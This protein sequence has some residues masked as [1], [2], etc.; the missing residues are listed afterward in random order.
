MKLKLLSKKDYLGRHEVIVDEDTKK[1]L[2]NIRKL[3]KGIYCLYHCNDLMLNKDIT[4]EELVEVR[5]FIRS[6]KIKNYSLF[7]EVEI[8]PCNRG[9]EVNYKNERY[10]VE[11]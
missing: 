5:K 2:L 9:L 1:D 7:N 10:I 3:N 11:K 4:F 8:I 6:N